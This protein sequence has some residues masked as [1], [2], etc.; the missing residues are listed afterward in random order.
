MDLQPQPGPPNDNP[1]PSNTAKFIAEAVGSGAP[2][3]ARDANQEGEV[4]LQ[5]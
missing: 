4:E 5:S 2:T 1:G 3:S